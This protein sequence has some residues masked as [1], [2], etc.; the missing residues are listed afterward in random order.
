MIVPYRE[1]MFAWRV[2]SCVGVSSSRA[3][4]LGCR[5]VGQVG[6]LRRDVVGS[7][8]GSLWSRR[9]TC[10]SHVSGPR[11][12]QRRAMGC[13]ARA[14]RG[15]VRCRASACRRVSAVPEV[16]VQTRP[17]QFSQ[18]TEPNN[19]MRGPAF[20]F[21]F[22]RNQSNQQRTGGGARLAAAG[23]S[24]RRR[25]LASAL[26]TEAA[27]WDSLSF[28]ISP[29]ARLLAVSFSLHTTKPITMR[30]LLRQRASPAWF[31][32]GGADDAAMS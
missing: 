7:L 10:K 17:W 31:T 24:C 32:L 16:V 23:E 27:G 11:A 19:Q 22:L 1:P 26:H 13:K 5:A 20:T 28:C 9:S 2:V 14:R 21:T 8:S 30:R 12:K 18:Q 29:S 4:G 6:W 25:T 15:Q 3:K